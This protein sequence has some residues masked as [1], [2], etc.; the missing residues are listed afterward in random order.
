MDVT[1]LEKVFAKWIHFQDD[2]LLVRL[3][4]SLCIANRIDADPVWAL[5]VGPSGA[6]K[7][8]WLSAIG[9]SDTTVFVN[10][11]TP[12]SLASGHGDGS[13]SLLYQLDGR[14]L[15]VEDMSAITEMDPTSRAM[16]FSFLRSAYNGSFTR[17]TGKGQIDWKG[18]FGMLG[19]A[20]L[21]IES[22][23]RM[24]TSLGERF[25]TIRPRVDIDNQ[26]DLLD[27]V[28]ASSGHK[29]PMKDELQKASETYL[30]QTFDTTSR[31][32][33]KSTLELLKGAA[34]ALAR[35]RTAA[36]RDRFSREIEFPLE[37]GEMGTRLLT[38]FLT[39]ALAAHAMGTEWD[40]VDRM[41]MRV[42]IDSMPYVRA[43]MLRA[44][45]K[46]ANEP[47]LLQPAMMMAQSQVGRHLEEL[48]LLKVIGTNKAR[49]WEITNDVV[50]FALANEA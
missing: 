8:A 42:V 39:I 11:L 9:G 45:H 12:Y 34:V 6:G 4:F 15:I 7:T 1:D 40:D 43:K 23:R 18:K 46:G 2:P 17:V 13:D 5:I 10:T 33:R 14:I 21:A 49:K 32:I 50:S 35:L 19:G 3:L 44:I 48:K 24:E 27:R 20:T 25:L 38:Q 37:V 16:L 31:A 28:V 36:S 30:A 47:R 41:I 29:S 22:G 26:D